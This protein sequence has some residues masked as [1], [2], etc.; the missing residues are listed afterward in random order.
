ME[1][2]SDLKT[3]DIKDRHKAKEFAENGLKELETSNHIN[4]DWDKYLSDIE[5]LSNRFAFNVEYYLSQAR[6]LRLER[7][8]A[9]LQE[10]TNHHDDVLKRSQDLRKEYEQGLSSQYGH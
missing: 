6:G 9:E 10:S 2:I 1:N 5:N 8:T 4:G 3:S 7:R